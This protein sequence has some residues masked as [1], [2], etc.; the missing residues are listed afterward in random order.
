MYATDEFH[1]CCV[2]NRVGQRA[3]SVAGSE[4]RKHQILKSHK[5]RGQ[6]VEKI[7]ERMIAAPR[8]F[9]LNSGFA[10][11]FRGLCGLPNRAVTSGLHAL[12]LR[13]DWL[14]VFSSA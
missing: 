5:A 7:G 12:R 2:L 3:E 4:L 1:R 6:R 10:G 14:T 8:R 11:R 9:L 13:K